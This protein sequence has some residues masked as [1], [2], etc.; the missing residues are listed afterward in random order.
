MIQQPPQQRAQ[1]VTSKVSSKS[2]QP[3]N[4]VSFPKSSTSTMTLPPRSVAHY[5]KIQKPHKTTPKTTSEFFFHSPFTIHEANCF[6]CVSR[7]ARKVQTMPYEQVLL[8]F[9]QTTNNQELTPIRSRK[10]N[11][12]PKE[13]TP[14]PSFTMKND[15]PS[16]MFTSRSN[17]DGFS[18]AVNTSIPRRQQ[19]QTTTTQCSTSTGEASQRRRS[20]LLTHCCMDDDLLCHDEELQKQSPLKATKSEEVRPILRHS[21]IPSAMQR[22]QRR[23]LSINELLN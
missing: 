8:D 20:F 14:I 2:Q 4:T 12:K 7:K 5:N 3:T 13:S 17:A 11:G 18:E 15:I 23:M 22:P 10:T 6:M 9:V 1:K 16:N 19:P 21:T